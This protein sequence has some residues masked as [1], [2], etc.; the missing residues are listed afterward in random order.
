MIVLS[1]PPIVHIT[2]SGCGSGRHFAG[3]RVTLWP[4]S[5]TRACR[6]G[7]SSRVIVLSPILNQ[8]ES[9]RS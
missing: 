6:F 7:S 3:G 9:Y 4:P 2:S 5:I 1:A 8:P